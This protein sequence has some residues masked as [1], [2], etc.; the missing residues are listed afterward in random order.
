VPE[1][2]PRSRICVVDSAR[3][4]AD[5]LLGRVVPDICEMRARVGDRAAERES[6]LGVVGADFPSIYDMLRC[7]RCPEYASVLP[8]KSS[9][10]NR[11]VKGARE[12]RLRFVED[13]FF[14]RE[15]C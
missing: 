10:G 13:R 6:N 14:R 15:A 11:E 1:T 8:S 2:T 5:L 9:R 12:S 4:V 7:E 3:W